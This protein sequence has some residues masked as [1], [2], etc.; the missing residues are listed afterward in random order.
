MTERRSGLR[1]DIYE[2]VHLPEELAGIRELDEVE[3][4]P[5]I[6]VI[7]EEDQAVVKGNLWL[8]GSYLGENGEPNRTLE[9]L[10]PVEITLPIARVHRLEDVGVEIE[11]FDVDLLTAR[12]LNVTGVLSLYGLEIDLPASSVWEDAERETVQEIQALPIAEQEEIV[13]VHRAEQAE[14]QTER[15]NVKR[16]WKG[17]PENPLNKELDEATE[18]AAASEAVPADAAPADSVETVEAEAEAEKQDQEEAL[19]VFAA[20]AYPPSGSSGLTA[21]EAAAD[22][23]NE[24][25][26]EAHEA[27]DKQEMKVAISGLKDRKEKE[28]SYLA[29]LPRSEAA[30]ETADKEPAKAASTGDSLEW[31]NLFIR[32]QGD[33]KKFKRMRICIVQKEETIE[34]IAQRYQINPREIVLYNR[35]ASQQLGEGQIIYIP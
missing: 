2:R 34:Q 14:A 10:I 22:E 9:Y 15:Q 6:Q 7:E 13:F 4:V 28:W 11:Q 18:A 26:A 29:N 25:R 30:A 3:L 17:I 16:D 8:S 23:S 21:S 35:L 12:S 32:D 1:F 31:K 20:D 5:H 33:E 24:F 19:P 27:E